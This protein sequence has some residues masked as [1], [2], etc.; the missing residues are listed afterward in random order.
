MGRGFSGE[1][2]SRQNI[3][4]GWQHDQQGN[5]CAPLPDVQLSLIA[6]SIHS[7]MRPTPRAVRK[8]DQHPE[9]LEFSPGVSKGRVRQRT[10]VCL[11]QRQ[12]VRVRS[13]Y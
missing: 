4:L 3:A 6:Q 11:N 5:E 9:Y 12:T 8:K 1:C 13:I 7:P 2:C 10:G